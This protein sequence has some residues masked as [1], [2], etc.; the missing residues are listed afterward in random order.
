MFLFIQFCESEDVSDEQN[1]TC[2][3]SILNLVDLAGSERADQSGATGSRQRE[4]GNIN[5]SL[6][7]LSRVIEILSERK[8]PKDTTHIPYRDSKLT[9]LLMD[10]LGG[11]SMTA[12]ICAITPVAVDQTNS[13]LG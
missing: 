11:N 12:I 13:T 2:L 10:S 1:K 5:K 9:F 6:L 3:V 7:H 8:S 4:A